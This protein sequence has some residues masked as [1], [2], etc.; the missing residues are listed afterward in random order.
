MLLETKSA[1]K[2]DHTSIDFMV[3]D[4]DDRKVN[5]GRINKEDME[6]M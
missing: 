2:Y 5:K 1:W 6:D 3:E 4:E